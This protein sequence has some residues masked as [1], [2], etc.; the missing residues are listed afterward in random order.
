MCGYH[1]VQLGRLC[2][3]RTWLWLW[4]FVSVAASATFPIHVKGSD[5]A[6]FKVSQ[7][8]TWP[9]ATSQ[10]ENYDVIICGGGLG[11]MSAAYFLTDRNLS[12]LILEKENVLGGLAMG[13]GVNASVHY[14]KGSAYWTQI[15]EEELHIMTHM[16][17][18]DPKSYAIPPP[19]DSYYFEG[20]FFEDLWEDATLEQLPASFALFKYELTKACDDHMIPEQPIEEGDLRLDAMNIPTWIRSMPDS[21]ARHAREGKPE[22]QAIYARYLSD[23]HCM[24]L[25]DDPMKDVIDLMERYTPSALGGPTHLISALAFANFYISEIDVRYATEFGTGGFALI[26]ERYLRSREGKALTVKTGTT[27][28]GVRNMPNGVEVDYARP[29]DLS[30][31]STDNHHHIFRARARYA[32]WAAQLKFVPDI[33]EGF[34]TQDFPRTQL[35]QNIEYTHYSVHVATLQG[36]PFRASYD[37]WITSK[38]YT[39][40]LEGPTDLILGRWM[41]LDG[42]GGYRSFEQ[43]PPDEFGVFTLYDP[44][45]IKSWVGKGYTTEQAVK[46]CERAI[47]LMQSTMGAFI[48]SAYGTEVN[49]REVETT[50]WPYSIHIAAPGHFAHNAKVLRQPFGNIF[51]ANNNLGTP[52]IEEALFRGHCAANNILTL[53]SP[54]EFKNEPWSRCPIDV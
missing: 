22:A 31:S 42:Y 33:V 16:G 24:S 48:H 38:L 45:Y 7:L 52:A 17:M 5:E 6:S 12:V 47:E 34:A 43:N 23:K 27:V 39:P 20:K 8:R 1:G 26:A 21:I 10:Q 44:L 54:G 3:V 35:I 53:L 14:S 29:S 4:L 50:R 13:S 28:L 51:F 9:L 37:T 2:L 30:S 18:F 36:H 40:V 49:I 41:E 11:G 15:Y 46:R 19:I 25:G 32:I